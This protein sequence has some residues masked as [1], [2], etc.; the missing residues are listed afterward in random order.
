M[1]VLVLTR[2][3]EWGAWGCGR[4]RCVAS[5]C[6]R[7]RTDRFPGLSCLRSP[8][9]SRSPLKSCCVGLKRANCRCIPSTISS[10]WRTS[11][12][13]F[14]YSTPFTNVAVP[15]FCF[16]NRLVL[17]HGTSPPPPLSSK[18]HKALVPSIAGHLP[19]V[20][21]G[22][23][24]LPSELE[25]DCDCAEATA[26]SDTPTAVYLCQQHVLFDSAMHKGATAVARCHRLGLSGR[27]M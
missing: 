8:K 21:K 26:S 16:R 22:G 9:C 14:R 13:P 11:V 19:L 20:A 24:G 4:D 27:H 17:V 10:D 18:Q 25:V 1:H 7:H 6:C 2:S 3:P 15:V 23:G 12:W 5:R